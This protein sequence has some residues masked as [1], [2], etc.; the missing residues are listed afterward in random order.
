MIIK[1][2]EKVAGCKGENENDHNNDTEKKMTWGMIQADSIQGNTLSRVFIL[3]NAPPGT[4]RNHGCWIF[5]FLFLKIFPSQTAALQQSVICGLK[6]PWKNLVA[7]WHSQG[8][9]VASY[10]QLDHRVTD[11]NQSDQIN[12][13]AGFSHDTRS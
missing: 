2:C 5:S 11:N 8:W 1:M 13:S 12:P 3:V 10:S 4:D 6:L 7:S 9:G